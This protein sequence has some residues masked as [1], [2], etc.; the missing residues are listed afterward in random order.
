M[1]LAVLEL[2]DV[3]GYLLCVLLGDLLDL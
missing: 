2:R 3:D 1:E